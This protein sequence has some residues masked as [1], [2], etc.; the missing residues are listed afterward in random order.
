MMK[1]ICPYD[2]KRNLANAPDY[3]SLS[4]L[5]NTIMGCGSSVPTSGIQT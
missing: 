2:R 5:E 3:C 1:N 4:R